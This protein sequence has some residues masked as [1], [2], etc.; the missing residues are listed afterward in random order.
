MWKAVGRELRAREAL[1]Y[2]GIDHEKIDLRNLENIL[3]KRGITDTKLCNIYDML[4][5][6]LE[7]KNCQMCHCESHGIDGF[8]NCC[9]N[10]VPSKCKKHRD[11]LKRCKDRAIKASDRLLRV[12]GNR[13]PLINY[14]M[15]YYNFFPEL[16]KRKEFAFVNKWSSRLQMDTWNEMKRRKSAKNLEV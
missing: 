2:R 8:C 9:E 14:E 12:V 15:S 6:Y 13:E 4:L 10:L 7:P 1:K 5:S 11:F 16:G 3:V